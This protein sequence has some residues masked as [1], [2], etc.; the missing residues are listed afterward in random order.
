MRNKA[1]RYPKIIMGLSDFPLQES[2]CPELKFVL[3][4]AVP[5]RDAIVHP[6]PELFG[7]L[8]SR[9]K[10]GD[11]ISMTFEEM[12][13]T[14]DTCLRLARRIETTIRGNEDRLFWMRDRGENGFFP[15]SVF[16]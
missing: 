7:E 14:V 11:L 16:T 13:E 4:N 15:N 1:M 9:R 5:L 8:P 2:N 3:E 12:E 6:A 10:E